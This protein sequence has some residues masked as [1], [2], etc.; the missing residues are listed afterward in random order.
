M[1]S[2]ASHSIVPL[3]LSEQPLRLSA[4]PVLEANSQ[5]KPL[6]L[7][8]M[9]GYIDEIR[10]V[11]YLVKPSYLLK[12]PPKPV[13][14]WVASHLGG[15]MDRLSTEPAPPVRP[16]DLNITDRYEGLE[17]LEFVAQREASLC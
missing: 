1:S 4:H 15:R 5:P 10:R 2:I 17:G 12:R 11:A 9:L 16:T 7:K 8:G 6:P 14:Q 3:D 13:S